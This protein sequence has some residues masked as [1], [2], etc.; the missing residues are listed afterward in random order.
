MNDSWKID[1]ERVS[2]YLVP[3]G[4]KGKCRHLRGVGQR[5]MLGNKTH[6]G[7][8]DKSRESLGS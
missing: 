1:S 8:N 7:F 6:S 4:L 3:I 5:N 2:E